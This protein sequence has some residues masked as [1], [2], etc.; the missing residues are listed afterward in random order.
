MTFSIDVVYFV[1]TVAVWQCRGPYEATQRQPDSRRSRWVLHAR[2]RETTTLLGPSR[3]GAC[4]PSRRSVQLAPMHRLVAVACTPPA[5]ALFENAQ[6]SPRRKC[7]SSQAHAQHPGEE[8]GTRL[9]R[10]LHSGWPRAIAMTDSK[11]SH[12]TA[13]AVLQGKLVHHN[14]RGRRP[15]DGVEPAGRE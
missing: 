8:G 14:D 9:E 6:A 12:G 11:I 7:L 13:S 2:L 10:T 1:L 5:I 15:A 3:D 4:T